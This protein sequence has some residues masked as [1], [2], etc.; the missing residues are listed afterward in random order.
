MTRKK[1]QTFLHR[2]KLPNSFLGQRNSYKSSRIVILPVS[3]EGTVSYGRGTKNAP[4]SI[5]HASRYIE[6]YDEEIDK[7]LC[8]NVEIHTFPEIKE[9]I[10]T[11]PRKLVSN[12]YKK[13]KKVLN[14]EKFICTLGG[15]HTVSVGVIQAYLE[16]Y[17]DMTVL[18]L[19]AHA[20]LREK[21][22]GTNH[23]HACVMYHFID[24][25]HTVQVGIR[26]LSGEEMAT[27]RKKKLE[28]FFMKDMY[29][30][31]SWIS[32]VIKKLH[33]KVYVTIDFDVFDTSLL[34]L[35]GTPEPG[36]MDWYSLI[37]LLKKI[38]TER[39]VVGFDLVEFSPQKHNHVPSYTCA[40]LCYKFLNYI[41]V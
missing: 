20:D 33:K 22:E 14:D 36:G 39:D 4:S 30:S 6:W 29:R 17:P 15:E 28:V 37:K 34:P 35:T 3:Y 24:K 10:S 23:S 11:H 38:S 41:F 27:I 9:N 12:I 8:K 21:Y 18:Q 5:I 25:G 2:E 40:K 16:K 19:D 32:N 7:E 1:K 26:S 31:Y 13:A